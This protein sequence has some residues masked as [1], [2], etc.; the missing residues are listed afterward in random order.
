MCQVNRYYISY[1]FVIIKR[2]ERYGS[3]VHQVNGTGRLQTI[4]RLTLQYSVSGLG[5]GL[6]R[7]ACF[8][9]VFRESKNPLSKVNRSTPSPVDV[10]GGWFELSHWIMIW[11]RV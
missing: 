5:L 8:V 10:L 6:S 1:I 4:G 11:A 7:N 9:K 3:A 2:K